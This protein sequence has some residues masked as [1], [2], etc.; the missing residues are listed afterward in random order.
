MVK[1][2]LSLGLIVLQALLLQQFKA[3]YPQNKKSS[4]FLYSFLAKAFISL[5]AAF[6]P[7]FPLNPRL[8]YM[9]S[10]SLRRWVAHLCTGCGAAFQHTS[11]D[12][13][14]YLPEH[15]LNNLLLRNEKVKQTLADLRA[16]EQIRK[17]D[18]W[19]EERKS[20]PPKFTEFNNI[21]DIEEAIKTAVPL[22]S[23]SKKPTLKQ[24]ICLR[25]FKLARANTLTPTKTAV[26]QQN[27]K[28]VLT[29]LSEQIPRGS[30]I[31]HIRDLL[32]FDGTD[33]PQL[34]QIA[35][36][37]NLKL[38]LIA[39]KVDVLPASYHYDRVYQW[40]KSQA[41]SPD[42][43]CVVS[44]VSG[45]GMTKVIG[46]LKHYK[47]ELPKA[48]TFV[49]GV[50]NAGKSSFI[51]K[52]ARMTWDLPMTKFK[53]LDLVDE[54]TTSPI[55]GTTL[56]L[57]PVQ[58]RRIAMT[59]TDT[60]GVPN[61]GQVTA[62]LQEAEFLKALVPHKKLNPQV[63][64]LNT[65]ISLFLGGLARLDLTAGNPKLI[66]LFMSNMVT[67][68]RTIRSKADSVFTKHS[69]NLLLP[70]YPKTMSLPKVTTLQL[71]C[72]DYK[73]AARDVCVH[74]LGWVSITGKGE[75][76]LEVRTPEAVGVTDR[77]PLMPYEA[78]F[79]RAISK[80]TK[81]ANLERWTQWR[82]E[83][84]A[85]NSEDPSSEGGTQA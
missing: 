41:S 51:N 70:A 8:S 76:T 37:K 66:T 67:F 79:E 17:S 12:L 14:G 5:S 73:V 13:E 23:I 20:S 26:V 57:V 71:N 49:V 9:L 44:S 24:V 63:I 18:F 53:E 52:I 77:A 34:Y 31:L 75:C 72:S 38:I 42:H 56:N 59:I 60:P 80:T 47:E 32:D 6:K 58:L 1:L 64:T 54:L 81:T 22:H 16:N 55:P 48:S 33:L 21:E 7:G 74:G 39:N 50:A 4:S 78:K 61:E 30:V 85:T 25:C 10:R 45:Q 46:L 40:V 62:H 68:H 29:W 15:K 69:G 27:S 19:K 65:D 2:S 28:Q 36:E 3:C 43:I 84:S 11:P 82:N 83:H 35:A